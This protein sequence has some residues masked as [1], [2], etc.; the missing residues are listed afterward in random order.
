MPEEKDEHIVAEYERHGIPVLVSDEAYREKTEKELEQIRY[1]A[2]QVAWK[3]HLA[4]E[5]SREKAEGVP[6]GYI[7]EIKNAPTV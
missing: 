6:S 5:E 4:Y 3:I 7:Q 2:R 1:H